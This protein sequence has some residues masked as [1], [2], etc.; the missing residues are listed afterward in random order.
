MSFTKTPRRTF[1]RSLGA[2]ALALPFYQLLE[3]KSARAGGVARRVVF[4]Y[5]PDGVAMGPDG[6][7]GQ[8][9]HCTGSESNFQLSSQLAPLGD[10]KGDCV[11]LK[12]ITLNLSD[13]SH[14][15]GAQKLLTNVFGGKG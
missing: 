2:A 10:F 8:S 12:G 3:S 5:F 6:D 9:W 1:L 11:F 15:D 13:G 4:F 14:D 7:L